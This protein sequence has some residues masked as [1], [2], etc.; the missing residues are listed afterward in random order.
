MHSKLQH[1]QIVVSLLKQRGIKNLVLCPGN[2]DVPLVHTVEDDSD[3]R[4][5]S[6]VD[7]RSAAF[8]A[9]GL[10]EATGEP[11]AFACTSSTASCNFLPAIKVFSVSVRRPEDRSD[12]Y[13]R[14]LHQGV[15]RS[16]R[17]Q[18]SL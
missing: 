3:F 14:A 10:A 12:K 2:R 16:A 15:R 13:V 7:E 1:V 9:L 17:H 8:F 4:C 18:K 11:A 6:I 5:F